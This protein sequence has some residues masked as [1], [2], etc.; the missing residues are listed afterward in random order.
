MLRLRV[1]D[2]DGRVVFAS[3]SSGA[4][5]E[6]DDEALDAAHGETPAEITHVN[7]DSNDTGPQGQE[8][9]EVYV[10]LRAGEPP[11]PVGVLE[12]YLPYAPIRA[13]ID[14]GQMGL[15]RDLVFGLAALYVALVLIASSVSRGLRRQVAINAYL[16]EH[17]ILTDLPN[18]SLFLR[19]AARRGEQR[20]GAE[21]SVIAIFDLDRFKEVNDSLGHHNGDLLLSELAERLADHMRPG[22]TIAR[23]GGDEF[24]VVLN[25]VGADEAGNALRRL[26][27]VVGEEIEVNGLPLSVEASV[28]YVVTPLDGTNVDELLQRA[29]VAMYVAKDGHLGVCRYD[30]DHDAYDA[31]NLTLVTQLRHAIDAGQLELFYQPKAVL[32]DGNIDALEA[33]VRW[34]HPTEGLIMP[35][36]FIPLVE[37]T[38]VIDR[39]T[40]WVLVSALHDATERFSGLSVAVNVSARSLTRNDFAEQ[41]TDALE[42]LGAPPDRL[43]LEITETALLVDPPRAA[44]VVTELNNAG[45]RVSLDDFGRGQTSLGYLS[46]LPIARAEDRPDVRARHAGEPRARRDRAVDDRPRPQPVAAGRRRRRRDRRGARL[47][48]RRRL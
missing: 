43:I 11:H 1:R 36:R 37:Q 41:V 8:A 40:E 45:V 44:E 30:S 25:G 5:E 17:D 3:D 34:H 18:R 29:D 38:D 4:G 22:D 24:G 42:R 39:L 32:T 23:L 2:L 10:P 28:G 16:A 48:A 13:D 12:V 20:R 35:D 19:R 6:D 7:S 46:A 15:Y 27:T 47:T 21:P 9:V 14:A 26:R 31:G 33:L